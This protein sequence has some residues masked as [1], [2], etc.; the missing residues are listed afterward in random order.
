MVWRNLDTVREDEMRRSVALLGVNVL[1]V[2]DFAE[3]ALPAT[4]PAEL[5]G[6]LVEPISPL[7]PRLIEG[8][9]VI[10]PDEVRNIART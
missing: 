2:L 10:R 9:I 1:R 3:E 4:N 7:K 5:T 8:P 6:R